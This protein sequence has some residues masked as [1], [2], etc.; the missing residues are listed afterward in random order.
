M[1]DEMFQ[2]VDAALD[3]VALENHVLTRW[4][5]EDVFGESLRRR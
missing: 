3:L 1:S 5:E 4:R 2:P